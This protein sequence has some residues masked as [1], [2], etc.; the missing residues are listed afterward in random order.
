MYRII[1]EEK[2]LRSRKAE[3]LLWSEA[4]GDSKVKPKK[5]WSDKQRANHQKIATTHIIDHTAGLTGEQ[6][7]RLWPESEA[8]QERTWPILLSL[9]G[10]HH[11]DHDDRWRDGDF[12]D[13]IDY[14]DGIDEDGELS[15]HCL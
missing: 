1:E 12:D 5:H 14:D 8:F 6:Q 3:S 7:S 2:E 4:T 15:R 11:V 10:W 9:A 13:D